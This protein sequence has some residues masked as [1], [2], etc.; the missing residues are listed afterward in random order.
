MYKKTYCIPPD[1]VYKMTYKPSM[2]T[3]I[4]IQCNLFSFLKNVI[5]FSITN[6]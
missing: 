2:I 3:C 5:Q 4:Q 1:M 6:G